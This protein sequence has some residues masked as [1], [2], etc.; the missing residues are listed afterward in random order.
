VNYF[1]FHVGD[2]AAATAHLTWDEDMAY[3]RL[4][5]AYYLTEQPIPLDK[6]YRLARATTP[7]QRKAVD[8]VLTEFFTKTD[9]GYQQ[10]RCNAEILKFQDKQEKA[11]R[12]ANERWKKQSKNSEGNANASDKGNTEAMRTHSEGNANQEPITNNQIDTS[13]TIQPSSGV[14]APISDDEKPKSPADW[15]EVF[16]QQHGVDVDH[17]SFHDR[18][19]FWPLAAAWTNAGVT[20]GQMRQA[21]AKAHAEAKDPIAWLPA[22]ADRVLASMQAERAAPAKSQRGETFAERD[23]ENGMRRWEQMTGQVHPDRRQKTADVIDVAEALEVLSQP[24]TR[25]QP[26]RLTA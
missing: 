18:K 19:K 17:R 9:I 14:R 22:Y 6:A 26:Q 8:T 16:A 3:T 7:A 20:V 13:S 11:Q 5:R 4:L 12:S 1:P 23:R 10:E 24:Q 2:Y 25:T 21:C 15:L